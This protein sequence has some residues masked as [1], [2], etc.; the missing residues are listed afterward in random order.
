MYYATTL[1]EYPP[2]GAYA[3]NMM[4]AMEDDISKANE[5]KT[6]PH[7]RVLSQADAAIKVGEEWLLKSGQ[8]S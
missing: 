7:E 1:E 4:K 8:A 2:Y 5:D 3:S 6:I